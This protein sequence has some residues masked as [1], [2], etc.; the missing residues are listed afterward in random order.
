MSSG[1]K[2]AKPARGRTK[3]HGFM[4]IEV[5]ISVLIFSLG[6]L[7][8]VGLQ[9][10]MMQAQTTAKDRA[11]A[12]YLINELTGLMWSDVKNLDKYSSGNC[13]NY[14]PC[15]NWQT[16][17]QQALPGVAFT[18]TVD[19]TTGDVLVTL[20]WTPASGGDAHHVTTATTIVGN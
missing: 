20:T 17:V 18:Q 12:S 15:A 14:T 9:A 11:D 2:F 3:A 16:K 7:G 8:L 10:S 5:M 19:T 13:A 1:K 6:V 4:L